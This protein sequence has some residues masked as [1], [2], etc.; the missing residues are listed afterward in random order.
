MCCYVLLC[1]VMCGRFVRFVMC[2]FWFVRLCDVVVPLCCVVLCLV[3][4]SVM[5]CS[6]HVM[7]CFCVMLCYDMP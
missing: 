7:L 6:W 5:V 1:V 3:S 2:M 4:V